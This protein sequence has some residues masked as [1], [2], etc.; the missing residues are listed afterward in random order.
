MYKSPLTVPPVD[1]KIDI[2]K[3]IEMNKALKKQAESVGEMYDRYVLCTIQKFGIEVDRDELVKALRYD[4][5]QYNKGYNDA[6]N[7]FYH[8]YGEWHGKLVTGGM[9][10]KWDYTCSECGG[11][12]HD[13]YLGMK[14]CPYCGAKMLRTVNDEEMDWD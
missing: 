6:K 9:S 5:D 11:V 12:Q 3:T 1:R 7:E 13:M 10:E 2:E 8:G 14:Y 4:R